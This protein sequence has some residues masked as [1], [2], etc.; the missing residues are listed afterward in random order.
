ML[1]PRQSRNLRKGNVMGYVGW[2]RLGWKKW[3]P[4][5]KS[6]ISEKECWRLVR[7]YANRIDDGEGDGEK[8]V[9]KKGEHPLKPK[10]GE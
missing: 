5:V 7:E 8:L 3:N 6:D 4:V 1:M 2:I 9:L 10:K